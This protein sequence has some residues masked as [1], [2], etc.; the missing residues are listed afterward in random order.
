MTQTIRVRYLAQTDT[1]PNRLKVW[2][3]G[4]GY[5]ARIVERDYDMDLHEQ[6]AIVARDYLR[7]V[8]VDW[9]S[10][11]VRGGSLNSS[12]DERAYVPTFDVLQLSV[13]RT[14]V[15]SRHV[16]AAMDRGG[17]GIERIALGRNLALRIEDEHTR[18][19]SAFLERS[20]LSDSHVVTGRGYMPGTVTKAVH[21]IAWR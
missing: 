13:I 10:T 12:G 1:Q 5:A 14:S 3:S 19:C 15:T 9:P 7:D 20:G 4:N 8:L 2:A 17:V 11:D 21:T 6:S 16:T 18:A